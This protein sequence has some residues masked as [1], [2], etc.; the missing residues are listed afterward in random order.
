MTT[1]SHLAARLKTMPEVGKATRL[2]WHIQCQ[3]WPFAGCPACIFNQKNPLWWGKMSAAGG[4]SC[5]NLLLLQIVVPSAQ[6]TKFRHLLVYLVI[7]PHIFGFFSTDQLQY[8][9]DKNQTNTRE[10][11]CHVARKLTQ[12]LFHFYKWIHKCA[13]IT[14]H[15]YSWWN[16]LDL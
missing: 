5:F 14:L 3:S 12:T 6:V 9:W 13:N 8:E 1:G 16:C 4:D 7:A 15:V 10:V 2:G 11:T